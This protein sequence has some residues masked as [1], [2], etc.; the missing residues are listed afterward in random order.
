[1][2]SGPIF[3]DKPVAEE[4]ASRAGCVIIS[5]SQHLE[6]KALSPQGAMRTEGS[7]RT[8]CGPSPLTMVGGGEARI[9][10]SGLGSWPDSKGKDVAIKVDK[11][12]PRPP[13][14]HT[15]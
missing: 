12:S 4:E 14:V 13:N 8:C 2:K 10:S 11:K 3:T 6:S 7:E 5:L 9:G 1:M 15:S